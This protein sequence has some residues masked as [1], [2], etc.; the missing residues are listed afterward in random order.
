MENRDI[1]DRKRTKKEL[2]DGKHGGQMNKDWVQIQQGTDLIT[3][4]DLEVIET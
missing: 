3:K 1:Q 2:A 4:K